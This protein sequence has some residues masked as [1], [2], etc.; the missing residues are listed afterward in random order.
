MTYEKIARLANVSLSTVS[1]AL[2]GSK[3]IS[4]ELREKIIK[5]ALEQGYFTKK[6]KR[7]IEYVD[8]K[9]ITIAI[10]CPEIVSVTYASEITAAKNE[11]EK[12]GAI[13]SVY[14]Y[15]FDA[16]KLDRIIEAITVGNRA[17]GIILCPCSSSAI[18]LKTS[19]PTVGIYQYPS[20]FDTISYNLNAAM[21]D[22]VKHLTEL[23]HKNIA[24]VGETNTMTKLDAYKDALQKH[25]LLCPDDNVYV[26]DERFEKIGYVA[27]DKIAAAKKLP[28]AVICAY[29]EVALSLIHKLTEK[30]IKVP[31]DI[32]V[33]GFNDVPSA[34]YSSVPLT[35]VRI[36]GKE[37]AERAVGLLYDKIFEKTKIIQHITIRHELVIRKSTAA[38]RKE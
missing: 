12:R 7:K 11:I 19:L 17:D 37:Q 38:S 25:G 15:D 22:A 33:V 1:K 32:S 4:E 27:A 28:T 8:D 14:V 30:G 36:Y 13:A 23:G 31:E 2:S 21:S 10:V 6:S 34:A 18:K 26:I 29:D 35:T 24:F 3:E 9:A 16:E 5:I 20:D